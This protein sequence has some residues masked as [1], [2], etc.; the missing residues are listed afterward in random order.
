MSQV[1]GLGENIQ[2]PRRWRLDFR[3]FSFEI[4]NEHFVQASSQLDRFLVNHFKTL[5]E[6]F[7]ILVRNKSPCLQSLLHVGILSFLADLS[8][9]IGCP[10]GVVPSIAKE[11]EENFLRILDGHTFLLFGRW[12]SDYVEFL[13]TSVLSRGQ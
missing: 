3:E 13:T 5:I 2:M 1:D 6:S 11:Q 7:K 8:I 9:E 4:I 10:L 12:L